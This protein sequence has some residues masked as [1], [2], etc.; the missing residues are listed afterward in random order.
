M[1]YARNLVALSALLTI[2]T[3]TVSADPLPGEVLKFQQLPMVATPINGVVYSG[4]DELSTLYG[5]PSTGNPGDPVLDYRG[6]SMADDF[7]DP[8][9][10][11]V[12]HVRWWGSYLGNLNPAN[13]PIDKFLIAFESDLPASQNPLGFSRPDQVLSS[14]IVNRGVLSPGSGTFTEKLIFSAPPGGEDI[15]EYNAELHLGK[16]FF[17]SP[18]KVY[19]LKIAALSDVSDFDIDG[20]VDAGDLAAGLSL[21]LVPQW[22]WHNRDYTIPDPLAL[23]VTPPVAP[24]EHDASLALG[25]PYPTPVWHFQDDSVSNG[26]TDLQL[27]PSMP[28]M[29]ANLFQN[30]GGYFP[31]R[32]RDGSDGPAAGVLADGT[33]H[34]G[35]GSFS[36]DLAFELYTVPEPASA[37]LL[38]VAL[39]ATL[40]GRPRR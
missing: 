40:A 27:D 8:F 9:A 12:L 30:P 18:A 24:G 16:E 33:T 7:A 11:P 10:S 20:D 5:F 28:N 25:L 38:A 36:K 26:Q 4:H 14:Q 22:G 34:V 1:N 17:Q 13:N 23:A 29:P 3:S 32:Y 39:G 2:L 35:I 15:Y 6:T 37:V 21:G 19:W 31:Q